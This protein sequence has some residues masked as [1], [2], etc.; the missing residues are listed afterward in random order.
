MKSIKNT[1]LGHLAVI[2]LLASCEKEIKFKQKEVEPKIVINA[3]QHPD[4]VWV[5]NV[6]GSTSIL[7]KNKPDS[8]PNATVSIKDE[9]GNVLEVLNHHSDGNFIST[10]GN[11]PLVGKTYQLEVSHINYKTVEATATFP[12]PVPFEI[13]D[14]SKVSFKSEESMRVK[15]RFADPIAES[16]YYFI[17]VMV[18][19]KSYWF[20]EFGNMIDSVYNIYPESIGSNDLNVE[21]LDENNS[22]AME[23]YVKDN[24]I[25][26]KTT[27]I[28]L[29]LNYFLF[30][31]SEYTN[32]TIFFASSSK[33]YY[34]HKISKNKYDATQGNPFAEPVIIYSNI[35]N[36]IGIF[37]GYSYSAIS[38]K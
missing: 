8:L 30:Q 2:L 35:K 4:S 23:L 6:S 33:E 15:I 13:V 5:I 18:T 10:Q 28:D 24:L 19:Y 26:G 27:E 14:T 32:I 34:L 36:G 11:K 20:D 25:N 16:N 12:S 1:L 9:G 38:L 37:A 3:L 22:K 29:Y 7:D 21:N 17:K 31:H